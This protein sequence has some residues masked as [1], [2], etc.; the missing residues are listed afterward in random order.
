MR[1]D[2]IKHFKPSEF[3]HSDTALTHRI[4]NYP[5]SWRDLFA[6]YYLAFYL[7]DVR[8]RYG[9][10]IVINSGYRSPD[11]NTAVGGVRNSKHLDGLAVDI[12]ISHITDYVNHNRIK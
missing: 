12:A 4:R 1:Y 6:I 5:R 2:V 9:K 8:V 11:V 3:L 7:D 10:P